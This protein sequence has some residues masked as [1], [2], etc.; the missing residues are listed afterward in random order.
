[1]IPGVGSVTPGYVKTSFIPVSFKKLVNILGLD[2]KIAPKKPKFQE[3][4]DE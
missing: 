3:H 2:D 1:M 4:H